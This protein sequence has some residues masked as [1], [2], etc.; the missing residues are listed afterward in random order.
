MESAFLPLGHTDRRHR[1]TR[2]EGGYIEGASWILPQFPPSQGQG[3]ASNPTSPQVIAR[4]HC[5]LA[6]I[7]FQISRP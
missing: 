2:S 7:S 5:I 6:L 1:R 3:H 4:S